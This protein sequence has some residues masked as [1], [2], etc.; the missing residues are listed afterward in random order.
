MPKSQTPCSSE[1][2]NATR[3]F[4]HPVES[5]AAVMAAPDTSSGVDR[6]VG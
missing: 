3:Y 2:D 1:F 5:V 4:T 6:V